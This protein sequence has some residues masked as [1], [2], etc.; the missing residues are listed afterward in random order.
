MFAVCEMSRTFFDYSSAKV[1]NIIE[2]CKRLTVF[3]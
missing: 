2:T 3:C 1:I